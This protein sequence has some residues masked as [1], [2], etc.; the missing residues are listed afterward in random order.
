MSDGIQASPFPTTIPNNLNRRATVSGV[1]L[2]PPSLATAAAV[3]GKKR[4]LI[5]G[6]ETLHERSSAPIDDRA[7]RS[8]SI[9]EDEMVYDFDNTRRRQSSSASIYY[10]QRL[11]RDSQTSSLARTDSRSSWHRF[12]TESSE[13]ETAAGLKGRSSS[14][15]SQYG[16][17][18]RQ[19][20][21]DEDKEFNALPPPPVSPYYRDSTYWLKII[22]V[23]SICKGLI[24]AGL[25]SSYVNEVSAYGQAAIVRGMLMLGIEALICMIYPIIHRWFEIN[26]QAK[27]L[28]LIGGL[29]SSF[30]IYFCCRDPTRSS[31][32]DGVV[33]DNDQ[34]D[35]N[36]LNDRD[37]PH[38]GGQFRSMLSRNMSLFFG[39]Y[40][41]SY[42][43]A[44]LLN[45]ALGLL[46]TS[47][48]QNLTD[49]NEYLLLSFWLSGML[50]IMGSFLY[51]ALPPCPK[52]DVI[53]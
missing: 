51:L 16:Q 14:T 4:R 32:L 26:T 45:V 7:Q 20:Q 10:Y 24:E 35:N 34:N 53:P 18:R 30:H 52:S 41:F 37:G 42:V 25:R 3:R 23:L 2:I 31:A 15:W 28:L 38:G 47:R 44:G 29:G 22:I 1:P 27:F 12:T 49:A 8:V 21:E 9:C 13:I 6:V 19:Q 40:F 39:T 43:G 36:S 50:S 11:R 5:E 48:A 46:F 17:Q 33:N